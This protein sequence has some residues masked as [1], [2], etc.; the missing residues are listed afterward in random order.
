M[1][2]VGLKQLVERHRKDT[3]ML[4]KYKDNPE[5]KELLEARIKKHEKAIIEYVTNN[6]FQAALNAFNL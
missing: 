3:E 5:R 6:K 1:T 2:N 4:R